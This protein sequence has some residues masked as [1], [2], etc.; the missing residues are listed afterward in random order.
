MNQALESSGR[1]DRVA[2]S[3]H[4]VSVLLVALAYTAIEVRGPHG[5]P[6][7]LFWMTTHVWAGTSLWC[8]SVARLLWRLRRGAPRPLPGPTLMVRLSQCVHAA[9][10]AFVLVQPVLGMLAYNLG[11]HAITLPGSGWSF[12]LV[13]PDRA[14]GHSLEHIH[15]LIG[16]VFY[17][18]IGVHAAA[19]LL[20]HFVYRDD[21]LRRMSW[22]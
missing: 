9:L 11:G 1:Y 4:W 7:R 16:N 18:V 5:D 22:G 21:T 20:H 12:V 10:Y 19:A 8:I 6:Y 15:G 13:G 2:V 17:G 3:L 14:L